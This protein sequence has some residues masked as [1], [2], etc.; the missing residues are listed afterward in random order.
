[1]ASARPQEDS[2][3]GFHWID[4]CVMVRMVGGLAL[5]E[6]C[7][8]PGPGYPESHRARFDRPKM[9]ATGSLDPFPW[10]LLSKS[11]DSRL[12]RFSAHCSDPCPASSPH[13]HPQK[14]EFTASILGEGP[15][16]TDPSL[17]AARL[18]SLQTSSVPCASLSPDSVS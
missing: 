6:Q 18:A 5:A 8:L 17:W 4:L 14:A 10:P 9:E 3:K 11:P 2:S 16:L 13:P 12:V 7:P 1:M 15:C